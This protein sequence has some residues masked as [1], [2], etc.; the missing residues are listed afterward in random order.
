MGEKIRNAIWRLGVNIAYLLKR[1]GICAGLIEAAHKIGVLLVPVPANDIEVVLPLSVSLVVPSCVSPRGSI[2]TM[3]EGL[4]ERDVTGLFLKNVKEGMTVVDIGAHIG[5]HT[6]LLSKLAGKRG[7][8]Y[9][10]EPD[11][12]N[13]KYLLQNLRKNNSDNVMAVPKAVSDTTGTALLSHSSILKEGFLAAYTPGVST[14]EAGEVVATTRLDDF[15]AE[16]DRGGVDLVKLDIDGGEYAA[17]KGMRG[18]CHK[19][20]S[21]RLVMEFSLSAMK[22][23]GIGPASIVRLLNELGFTEARIIE[24]GCRLFSLDARSLPKRLTRS[25]ANYNLFITN[26]LNPYKIK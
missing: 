4:Y 17:L 5:Y 23:N 7:R 19:N 8:V 25:G 18:V 10:F 2:R 11:S 26:G 6:V 13:F 22:R 9:A 3:A 12:A 16:K 24:Q 14:P 20:P 1:T 21:L 15:F